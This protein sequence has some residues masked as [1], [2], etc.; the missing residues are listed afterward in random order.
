LVREQLTQLD[1]D[2]PARAIKLGML[3]NAAIISTVS[4]YLATHTGIVIYDPVLRASTGAHLLS[5]DDLDTLKN[6]LLARIDLLT[7]NINEAECLTGLTIH[8]TTDIRA[9]AEQL[10]ALGVGSVLI[11]GGHGPSYQGQCLDYWTDGDNAYWLAAPMIATQHHHGSGCTLSAAITAAVARGYALPDALVL[12]KAYTTCGIRTA[13]P[14]GQGAGPIAHRGWPNQWVD[15]P[16]VSQTLPVN[17]HFPRC[18]Q[19]LGLYVLVDSIEWLE[20]LLPLGVKTLQLRIKDQSLTSI[21]DSIRHAVKLVQQYP[22]VRL[23]INDY[24][25]QA[26]A[27]RAYG[28]HLGQEDLD[29]ADLAA[30]S[31]A[32]LRLGVSVHCYHEIA[33]AHAIQPSYIAIGS[34][35]KTASKAIS[36]PPVGVAQLAQWVQLLTDHYPLT[37]IG[38]INSERAVEVLATGIGSCAMISAVTQAPDYRQA[39]SEL[40]ALPWRGDS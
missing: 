21:D 10:L 27:H 37:A 33:R 34:I 8:S 4:D 31:Q 35:Y 5:P 32:G 3:A 39:V 40:L 16:R 2:L 19:A 14:L 26:I 12:A 25:Q 24:W 30:I 38:G 13:Q 7:P 1:R 18:D 9:A 28:V 23:W 15:Y 17:Y 29:R 22:D 36:S 11:T 6:T 20:K